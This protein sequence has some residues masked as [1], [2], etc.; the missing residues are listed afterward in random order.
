MCNNHKTCNVYVHQ[1]H[2]FVFARRDPISQNAWGK[3]GSPSGP[4]NSSSK[5]GALCWFAYVKR[6]APANVQLQLKDWSQLELQPTSNSSH[7]QLKDWRQLQLQPTSN[8][9][10]PVFACLCQATKPNVYP[11]G[12]YSSRRK[13]GLSNSHKARSWNII[14]LKKHH[15]ENSKASLETTHS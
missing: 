6:Q 10:S 13:G 7:L 11:H 12:W 14:M 4:A 5:I 3:W 1:N 15:V 2:I 9:S 8:F